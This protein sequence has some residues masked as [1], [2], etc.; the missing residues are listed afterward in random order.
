[1]PGSQIDLT[2]TLGEGRV[3]SGMKPG[4][5]MP[6][7]HS[8]SPGL[9][10]Q[11]L[12]KT[13]ISFYLILATIFESLCYY[14]LSCIWTHHCSR[15]FLPCLQP[16]PNAKALLPQRPSSSIRQVLTF[17]M[18]IFLLYTAVGVLSARI[19]EVFGQGGSP[20]LN[21]TKRYAWAHRRY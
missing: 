14:H 15:S 1:M 3:T 13:G 19:L 20:S 10:T 17:P 11:S 7:G 5:L 4:S 9:P 8:C 21:W 16:T 6:A 2:N 18:F 12:S